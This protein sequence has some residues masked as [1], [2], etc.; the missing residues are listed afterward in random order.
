M[1]LI[2]NK[3]TI[4]FISLQLYFLILRGTKYWCNSSFKTFQC[5]WDRNNIN[6]SIEIISNLKTHYLF[7]C[8]KTPSFLSPTNISYFCYFSSTCFN[9]ISIQCTRSTFFSRFTLHFL[10]KFI[11]CVQFINYFIFH[12]VERAKP[13]LLILFS[14]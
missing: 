3:K 2:K 9:F 14:S 1:S 11:S 6:F 4:N 13:I 7:V 10:L 12:D 8:P 5:T